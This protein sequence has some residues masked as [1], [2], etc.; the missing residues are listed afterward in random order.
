[1]DGTT[2]YVTEY[3]NKKMRTL[4]TNTK[5]VR[6]HS[7]TQ[8]FSTPMAIAQFGTS[9]YVAVTGSH[10]VNLISSNNSNFTSPWAGTGIS[11]PFADGA[12]LNSTF[13]GPRGIATDAAGNVYVSDSLNH[14]IRKIDI[15]T[16]QVSTI[17]GSVTADLTGG[18]INSTTGTNAKFNLP[19]TVV[20]SNLGADA[21]NGAL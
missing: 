7:A 4:F 3:S 8:T 11:T 6:D 9:I 20:F 21:L 18:Y 5:D 1:M 2:L 14:V 19:T 15:T 10:I 13:N 12:R 17:A 16:N